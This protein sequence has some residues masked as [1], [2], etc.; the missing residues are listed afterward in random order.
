MRAIVFALAGV[1]ATA[2]AV[3]GN[4]KRAACADLGITGSYSSNWGVVTLEQRGCRVVGAWTGG[5]IDGALDGN[6]LRYEWTTGDTPSGRGVFVV[7][8]DGEVIG[9]WGAGAD[10][11]DGG[12]WRLVPAHAIASIAH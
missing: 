11:I 7:A 9:T 4:T 8:S 12:G 6:L 5:R 3:S 2:Q 1:V 10:D